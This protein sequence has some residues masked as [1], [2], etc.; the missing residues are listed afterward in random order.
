MIRTIQHVA[1]SM[2][3]PEDA[4]RFYSTFGMRVTESPSG[5]IARCEGR[6]QDQIVV[7]EGARRGLDYLSFGGRA[8][9]LAATAQ[10]LEQR[11]V[12]LLDP[13]RASGSRSAAL[14]G[15]IRR[16]RVRRRACGSGISTGTSFTSARRPRLRCGRRGRWR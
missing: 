12:K 15:S 6:A 16:E 5:V 9:E 2:P 4:A 14:S 1:L 11:G 7:T 8:S 3:R 13:P 10:R